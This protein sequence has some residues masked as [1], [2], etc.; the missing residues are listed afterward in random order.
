MSANSVLPSRVL[1]SII[2][3]WNGPENNAIVPSANPPAAPAPMAAPAPAPVTVVQAVKVSEVSTVLHETFAGAA[4]NAQRQAAQAMI[5]SSLSSSIMKSVAD[6]NADIRIWLGMEA[7]TM[8]QYGTL[9]P[10]F[11][12]LFNSRQLILGGATHLKPESVVV[13]CGAQFFGKDTVE[14]L[15]E[16][17]KRCKLLILVDFDEATLK[18]LSEILDPKK[19]KVVK[20]DLTG[21]VAGELATFEAELIA[22]RYP[23]DQLMNRVNEFYCHI[24]DQFATR[25]IKADEILG[26]EAAHADY[27]VSS[28]VGS[29]LGS[30]VAANLASFMENK[31]KVNLRN[32]PMPLA[33][34]AESSRASMCNA[35]VLKHMRDIVSW[36]APAGHVYFADT[37]DTDTGITLITDDTMTQVAS[38]SKKDFKGNW[39]WIRQGTDVVYGVNAI[40]ITELNPNPMQI[41]KATGLS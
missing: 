9:D 2:G 13:V 26:K 18:A 22:N 37:V 15:K 21:G 1:D 30:F 17:Q 39:A 4:K 12:H 28:L 36:T 11:A 10:R 25:Q 34:Q 27:V 33:R 16:L 29:T 6:H 20:L 19:L 14:P 41:T 38:Y 8:K 5:V 32:V 23:T 31:L 24:K 7:L 3:Y 35:L 40:L